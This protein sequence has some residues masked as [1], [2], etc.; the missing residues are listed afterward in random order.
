MINLNDDFRYFL[1]TVQQQD[2]K[3]LDTKTGLIETFD[4]EEIDDL[5]ADGMV[6]N[7]LDD[8]PVG[9]LASDN[10]YSI[11]SFASTEKYSGTFPDSYSGYELYNHV[12][13]APNKPVVIDNYLL[14]EVECKAWMDVGYEIPVSMSHYIACSFSDRLEDGFL[15]AYTGRPIHI[16]KSLDDFNKLCKDSECILPK[17]F[18]ILAEELHIDLSNATAYGVVL[19]DGGFVRGLDLCSAMHFIQ[20]PSSI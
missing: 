6:V 13:V 16:C 3:V 14:L 1:L 12:I 4:K 15:V 20:L 10:K 11:E 5:V 8:Y 9:V 18:C 19:Y 17:D 7:T 2:Y